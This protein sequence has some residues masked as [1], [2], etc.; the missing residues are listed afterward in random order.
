MSRNEPDGLSADAEEAFLDAF[1]AAGFVADSLEAAGEEA[2]FT[3]ADVF[4]ARAFLDRG[5]EAVVFE[6][7]GLSPGL[8]VGYGCARGPEV[9][10]AAFGILDGR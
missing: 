2:E 10:R 7:G 6:V 4:S 1:L 9:R 3:S 8:I 5:F